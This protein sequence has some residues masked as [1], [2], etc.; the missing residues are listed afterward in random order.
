MAKIKADIAGSRKNRNDKE[1]L[2]THTDEPPAG[3]A[4]VKPS[5]PEEYKKMLK[6]AEE[7]TTEPHRRRI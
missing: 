1:L 5:K 3:T 2:R 7:K 4:N 6:I